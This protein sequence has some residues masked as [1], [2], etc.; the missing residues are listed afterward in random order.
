MAARIIDGGIIY[1]YGTR[2]EEIVMDSDDEY[3]CD[4]TQ[5]EVPIIEPIDGASATLRNALIGSSPI[6]EEIS[7]NIHD[8]CAAFAE[9]ALIKLDECKICD[10]F[11]NCAILRNKL[12]IGDELAEWMKLWC[13]VDQKIF[14]I[15]FRKFI[16]RYSRPRFAQ[17]P[18]RDM[19]MRAEIRRSPDRFAGV[20]FLPLTEGAHGRAGNTFMSELPPNG[21]RD[22]AFKLMGGMHNEDF[23]IAIFDEWMRVFE[24]SFGE[25][26]AINVV[27]CF[28]PTTKGDKDSHF[29]FSEL[30]IKDIF[31]F[32][33]K[34][35][36]ARVS[37]FLLDMP[38]LD[39]VFRAI[40]AQTAYGCIWLADLVELLQRK[41]VLKYFIGRKY[42]D[43][44]RALIK[45]ATLKMMDIYF[46][47]CDEYKSRLA[48]LRAQMISSHL[49]HSAFVVIY[50]IA[51][52]N[53][54]DKLIAK[55]KE[56]QISPFECDD[57]GTH[58]MGITQYL[59][60]NNNCANKMRRYIFHW[61]FGV[62]CLARNT[63]LGENSPIQLI[64]DEAAFHQFADIVL[65]EFPSEMR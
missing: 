37:E 4:D 17:L 52:K 26:F 12:D 34:W 27:D 33:S 61:Q 38:Q 57:V 41:T 42:L 50:N 49:F 15:I 55:M 18:Y 23:V 9:I 30:H 51:S 7:V 44:L 2:D 63:R 10:I 6:E 20:Q 28:P 5:E 11:D 39:C 56:L 8:I 14:R 16:S 3:S 54:I 22:I 58:I 21:L 45:T 47:L 24:L 36:Y 60:S 25:F 1:H 46:E 65:N 31:H 53:H 13:L 40:S 32:L 64:A 59:P 48:D 19:K 43:T 29:A 35:H 62:L